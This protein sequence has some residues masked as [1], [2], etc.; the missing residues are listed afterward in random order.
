MGVNTQTLIDGIMRRYVDSMPEWDYEKDG[1]MTFADFDVGIYWR[2]EVGG[3][4]LIGS[5]EPECDAP[6]YIYPEVRK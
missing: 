6:Y 2:P 1:G 4:I 3:K 5:I